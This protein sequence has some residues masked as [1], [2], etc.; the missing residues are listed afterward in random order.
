SFAVGVNTALKENWLGMCSGLRQEGFDEPALT[1]WLHEKIQDC[2]GLDLDRPLTFGMLAGEGPGREIVLRLITTDLS[3]SRPVDLPLGDDPP[4]ADADLKGRTISGETIYYFD[5]AEF[6]KLF[7]PTVVAAMV[8]DSDA[9]TL[10]TAPDRNLRRLPGAKLPIVVAARLSLSFPMLVS[11]VPLWSEH[12][13]LPYLVEH[14]MSDGGICSNFP[15]HFFDSLF[16]GRPTF[17]LDLEPYPDP[18][19]EAT[20]AH[21]PYVVFGDVP[22]PPAFSSVDG[23]VTFFRQLLNAARNWRDNM[24]SELPGYRDR[25]CQIRLTREQGG[26]NLEMPSHVV[27]ALIERGQEAGDVICAAPPRGFD[28]NRHRFTR[29][30]TLMQALQLNLEPTGPN[31]AS[32]VADMAQPSEQWPYYK[33]HAPPWWDDAKVLATNFFGGVDWG[34]DGV[35]NFDLDAPV[36]KPALRITPSV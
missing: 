35:T 36:P 1:E 19:Q 15:I 30:L 21:E 13:R 32:F 10:E 28:W 11:T 16:P 4:S 5:P 31:F 22:R 27:D 2:A 33:G 25:V 9:A 23:I 3:L 18:K 24:Q 29:F 26:L 17:G 14:C 20:L 7:P 6:C 8:A 34:T 12:P